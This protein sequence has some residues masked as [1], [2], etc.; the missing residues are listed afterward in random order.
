MP[1]GLFV[2]RI[3]FHRKRAAFFGRLARQRHRRATA[4]A[5]RALAAQKQGRPV[6]ARQLMHQA[7]NLKAL[8][9]RARLRSQNHRARIAEIRRRSE[10]FW[11]LAE[12][13]SAK[14]DDREGELRKPIC[15][16]V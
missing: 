4:L 2:Q 15:H 13:D 12:R 14:A 8:A 1:Q 6:A 10:E 5:Q 11:L 16:L 9:G 3:D 7:L